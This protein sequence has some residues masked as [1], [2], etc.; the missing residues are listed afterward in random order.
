VRANSSEKNPY[1]IDIAQ[2]F[3]I[4]TKNHVPNIR[5]KTEV[6]EGAN[7]SKYNNNS[8]R[9]DKK[10]IINFNDTKKGEKG[11]HNR[12]ISHI[13]QKNKPVSKLQLNHELRKN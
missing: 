7:R 3:K 5:I 8:F 6:D 4:G 9:G 11:F 1:H 2:K 13:E 10:P 12:N